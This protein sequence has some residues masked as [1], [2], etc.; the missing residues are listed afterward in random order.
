MLFN[1]FLRTGGVPVD[2]W[3]DG[4]AVVVVIGQNDAHFVAAEF[5]RRRQLLAQ[6][7]NL[8]V[9]LYRGLGLTVGGV[10]KHNQVASE[11]KQKSSINVLIASYGKNCSY[12]VG[13][14]RLEGDA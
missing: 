3:R 6:C 8:L 4:R 7:I 14:K 9:L 2:G 10:K 12:V 13:S 11:K 1:S 5:G